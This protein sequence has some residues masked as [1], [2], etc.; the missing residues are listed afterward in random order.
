[1][2]TT[3]RSRILLDSFR[4]WNPQSESKIFWQRQSL[5]WF[6]QWWI[7]F[8]TAGWEPFWTIAPSC[9]CSVVFLYVCGDAVIFPFLA[10]FASC[11]SSCSLSGL[12][13]F[14]RSLVGF[15][16]EECK[17][18][19]RWFCCDN[20]TQTR[21]G[22]FLE[23]RRVH[24]GSFLIIISFARDTKLRKKFEKVIYFL[25][26][27]SLNDICLSVHPSTYRRQKNNNTLY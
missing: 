25:F 24:V 20:H 27:Y 4:W 18:K 19:F 5:V 2:K 1:M 26:Y 17:W 13:S 3:R 7:C 23:F 15:K 16:M 9:S 11:L 10:M 22:H 14:I 8:S 21:I 12:Y 6:A